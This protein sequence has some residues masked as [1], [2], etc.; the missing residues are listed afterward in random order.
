MNILN[1]LKIEQNKL[2]RRLEGIKAAIAWE[3]R[4]DDADD[5]R[6]DQ[7]PNQ[8]HTEKELG[9]Q[10]EKMT[11][12]DEPISSVLARA[13]QFKK[14]PR[15]D[16]PTMGYKYIGRTYTNLGE[17]LTPEELAQR[18]KVSVAWITEKRRPRC[19]NPIPAIR[20]ASKSGLIGIA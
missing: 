2:Q 8:R 13:K 1:A 16:S 12:S 6:S 20:S 19:P 15:A 4:E 17:I 14:P 5:E 11:T 18:L 9:C 3:T 7:T 10:K